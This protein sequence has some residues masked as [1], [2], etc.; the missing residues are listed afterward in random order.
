MSIMIRIE[1]RE[2]SILSC[3]VQVSGQRVLGSHSLRLLPHPVPT[4]TTFFWGATVKLHR[5][6]HSWGS[7]TTAISGYEA[8]FRSS[9]SCFVQVTIGITHESRWVVNHTKQKGHPAVMRY[10]VSSPN[11]IPHP[12]FLVEECL[13]DSHRYRRDG[14]RMGNR[15]CWETP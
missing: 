10:A 1:E 15:Y 11:R 14:R 4:P 2:S 8:H 13:T 5:W 12:Q 3:V 7:R 9:V 6:L